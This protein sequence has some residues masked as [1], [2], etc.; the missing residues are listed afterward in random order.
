MSQRRGRP[1]ELGRLLRG[2]TGWNPGGVPGPVRHGLEWRVRDAW[3]GGLG[4][5]RMGTMGRTWIM[6]IVAALA[7]VC[8]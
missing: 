8:L 4:P 6:M 2:P 1:K 7:S 3:G 5:G